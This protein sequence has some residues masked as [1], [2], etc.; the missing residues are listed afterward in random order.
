MSTWLIPFLA[1]VAAGLAAIT[2]LADRRARQELPATVAHPR[3]PQT[4][5]RRTRRRS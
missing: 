4:G 3:P 5:P 2:T 1:T